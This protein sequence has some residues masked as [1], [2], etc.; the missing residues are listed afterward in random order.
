VNNDKD[1]PSAEDLAAM[2]RLQEEFSRLEVKDHL[3]YM[4]QSLAAL[5]ARRIHVAET[6]EEGGDEAR[7]E[8]ARLAIDAFRALL[9]VLERF[10]LRHEISMHRAT[11]SQ[12]QIEYVGATSARVAAQSATG[13]EPAEEA[14]A[15]EGLDSDTEGDT[16]P[17]VTPRLDE[18]KNRKDQ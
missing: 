15:N 10:L 11:L 1:Y 12:L 7:L 6:S 5:A 14:R 13:E 8:Q 17:D 3:G 2:E 16:S 9:Q 4:M 18:D